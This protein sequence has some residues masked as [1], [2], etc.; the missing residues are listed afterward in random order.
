MEKM[1]NAYK[2]LFR[3]P[4]RKTCEDLSPDGR[5]ILKWSLQKGSVKVC[6]EIKWLSIRSSYGPFK[7]PSVLWKGGEFLN[8]P[9]GFS[10]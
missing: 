7:E 5:T 4:E 6:T 2:T 8:Q 1:K 3:K 10:Y 9:S